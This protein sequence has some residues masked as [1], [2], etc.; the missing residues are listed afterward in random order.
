GHEIVGEREDPPRAPR[1]QLSAYAHDDALARSRGVI[2]IAIHVPV[3][4]SSGPE[5]RPARTRQREV[6]GVLGRAAGPVAEEPDP[7]TVAAPARRDASRVPG[8]AHRRRD[9]AGIVDRP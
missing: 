3:R 1:L 2:A 6:A 8:A 5:Q 4:A 7:A 9:D